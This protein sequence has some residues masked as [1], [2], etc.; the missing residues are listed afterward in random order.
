MKHF[1]LYC[2]I[3]IITVF[4]L[5]AEEPYPFSIGLSAMPRISIYNATSPVDE[6]H[7]MAFSGVPDIGLS[8]YV[9]ASR[10][11]RV[12]ITADIAYA[13]YKNSYT[14]TNTDYARTFNYL[15]ITP[16]LSYSFFT[17]GI[18]VGVP[19]GYERKNVTSGAV[20][21]EG[22]P[23]IDPGSNPPKTIIKYGNGKDNMSLL[24]E[25]RVGISYPVMNNNGSRLN[26][27]AN[28]GLMMNNLYKDEY[29]PTTNLQQFNASMMSFAVG[30]QYLFGL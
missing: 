27:N 14:K 1:L 7:G 5:Y 15:T 22:W 12:G 3:G 20:E 30:V 8:I 17:V 24:I 10:R 29:Y 16:G 25:P 2:L 26:V 21:E 6:T 23:V 13:T 18:A 9:P 28:I 4:E 19:I 11:E